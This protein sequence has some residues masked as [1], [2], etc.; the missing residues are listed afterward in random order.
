M[1]SETEIYMNCLHEL[2]KF[3]GYTNIQQFPDQRII[4]SDQ[5]VSKYIP[6]CSKKELTDFL[7]KI[8]TRDKASLT[9]LRILVVTDNATKRFDT[10]DFNQEKKICIEYIPAERM[11]IPLTDCIVYPKFHESDPHHLLRLKKLGNIR[12]NE[13]TKCFEDF[14][15]IVFERSACILSECD[16][17][18]IWNNV[19]AGDIVLENISIF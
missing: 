13:D 14:E 16:Q 11:I 1:L 9:S 10:T 6:K 4:Q 15:N 3:S 7:K 2:F 17:V 5:C 19:R 18:C 12:D 8:K